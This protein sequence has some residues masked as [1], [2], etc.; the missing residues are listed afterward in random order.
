MTTEQG[1]LAWRKATAYGAV[2]GAHALVSIIEEARGEPMVQQGSIYGVFR[3][4]KGKPVYPLYLWAGGGGVISPS[5]GYLLNRPCLAEES[6]RKAFYDEFVKAVGPL[7]T[8]NLK[9]YPSFNVAKLDAAK[10]RTAFA[11]VVRQFVEAAI[12]DQDSRS[13]SAAAEDITRAE[14]LS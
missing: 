8:R 1:R 2:R 12:S 6:T 3:T 4:S 5:F 13:Q 7:S 14:S 10:V 9:G 11:A